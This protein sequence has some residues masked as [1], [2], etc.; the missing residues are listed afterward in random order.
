MG[1]KEGGGEGC[2]APD[3]LLNTKS[4]SVFEGRGRGR[5]RGCW[6]AEV[7]ARAARRAPPG[8]HFVAVPAVVPGLGGGDRGAT[9]SP[10]PCGAVRGAGWGEASMPRWETYYLAR[11]ACPLT[12]I[13]MQ[14][15][16]FACH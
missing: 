3:W 13:N 5:A 11:H 14:M 1:E 8:S 10:Q 12:E 2:L 7:G 4:V 9:C 6:G 15:S 16:R